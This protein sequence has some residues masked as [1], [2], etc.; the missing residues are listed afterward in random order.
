MTTPT[1]MSGF[2][3]GAR[4]ELIW[5][6]AYRPEFVPLLVDY[7]G[8]QPGT[9]IL[10]AGCGSGFLSRLLART[11][12]GVQ[13]V[14]LDADEKMLALAHQMVEREGL[15]AQV[16]LRSGDAYQIPFPDDAFDLVTSQTLL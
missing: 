2:F 6:Y 11:L 10:D 1:S 15:A 7:L 5:R 4:L 16:E 3:E 14:G 9:R 8:A 12:D 13:I